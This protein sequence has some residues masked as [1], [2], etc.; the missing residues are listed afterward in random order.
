M[1]GKDG[2]F[3]LYKHHYEHT[4]LSITDIQRREIASQEF[5]PQLSAFNRAQY[6]L[7][8]ES[9]I[10]NL[11]QNARPPAGLFCSTAYYLDPNESKPTKR[12]LI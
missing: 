9:L 5:S 12:G 1:Q 2:L 10:E 11:L 3:G 6:F 4:D 8:K 7:T